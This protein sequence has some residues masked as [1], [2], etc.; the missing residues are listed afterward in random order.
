VP[1]GAGKQYCPMEKKAHILKTATPKFAK[2]ISNKYAYAPAKRVQEDLRENHNREISS[3]FIQN[4]SLLVGNILLKQEEDWEYEIPQM[5][6]KVKTISLGLD[7]TCMPMGE[8]NWREAMCGTFT[9]YDENGERMD[10]IYIANAP[11]YGK[12]EFKKRFNKE[13]LSIKKKFP[14]AQIVGLAD[15]AKENWPLLEK[16]TDTNI[17]DYFHATEYLSKASKGFYPRSKPKRKNWG[18]P[19]SSVNILKHK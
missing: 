5:P 10:T 4:T 7:G 12:S 14:K 1:L 15:G 16:Y 3:S 8:N 17:L 18:S 9:F 2:I 13:V 6:K 11:E 19:V